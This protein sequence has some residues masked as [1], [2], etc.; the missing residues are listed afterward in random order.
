MS[1]V[2]IEPAENHPHHGFKLYNIGPK[3]WNSK[4]SG[5]PNIF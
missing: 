4:K 1:H 3:D 2:A 5:I